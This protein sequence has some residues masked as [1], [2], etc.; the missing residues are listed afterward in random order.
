MFICLAYRVK[1]QS[2]DAIATF[3]S[4]RGVLAAVHCVGKKESKAA[5]ICAHL[6]SPDGT[7]LFVDDD[8]REHAD[9]MLRAHASVHQMLFV[10]AL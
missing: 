2:Q 4:E 9:P 7:A 5:V 6:R 1:S 3:L 10:R 8:I